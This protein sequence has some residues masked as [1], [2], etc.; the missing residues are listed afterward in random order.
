[1]GHV[2]LSPDGRTLAYATPESI[3]LLDLVTEVEIGSSPS[4]SALS[5]AFSPDGTMLAAN[6]HEN[7][8][9]LWDVGTRKLRGKLE[10][11]SRMPVSRTAFSIRWLSPRTV[12]TQH[13]CCLPCL[14]QGGHYMLP[15]REPN[16]ASQLDYSWN[17]LRFKAEYTFHESRVIMEFTKA[18][19][20]YSQRCVDAIRKQANDSRRYR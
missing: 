13:A 9:F 16:Y 8:I 14:S 10:G 20:A 18:T 1:V 11:V 4:L 2:T 7:A 19:I 15:P 3:R 17:H 6:T 12:G 5:L